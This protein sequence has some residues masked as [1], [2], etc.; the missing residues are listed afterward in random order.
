MTDAAGL[1]A[2]ANLVVTIHGA[3]DAPVA[4]DDVAAATEAGGVG[5]AR[6]GR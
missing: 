4:D 3:N 5:N 1:T 6:A 2:T